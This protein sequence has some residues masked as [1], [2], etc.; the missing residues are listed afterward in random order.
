MLSA[1]AI[2]VEVN[3]VK[4]GCLWSLIPPS[5]VVAIGLEAI[6]GAPYPHHR[7]IQKK[8]KNVLALS[9]IRIEAYGIG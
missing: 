2:N 4:K 8:A 9:K 7:S 3:K 6:I 1:P 5:Q